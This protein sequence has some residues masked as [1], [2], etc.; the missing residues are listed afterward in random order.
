M[1]ATL[2]L[3]ERSTMLKGEGLIAGEL[4]ALMALMW[5]SPMVELIAVAWEN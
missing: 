1:L 4:E 2:V 3:L 5:V